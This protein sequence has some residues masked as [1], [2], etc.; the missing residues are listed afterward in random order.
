MLEKIQNL[1]INYLIFFLILFNPKINLIPLEGYHGIRLDD[2]L[3]AGTIIYFLINKKY[4]ILDDSI[5]KNFFLLL[6]YIFFVNF[7][8]IFYLIPLQSI[9]LIRSIEYLSLIII[10]NNL[11]VSKEDI[12]FLIK[13]FIFSNLFISILQTLDL[14]G[15]FSSLG[16][17]NVDHPNNLRA[18]GILGGSWE[19]AIASCLCYF[20]LYDQKNNFFYLLII[21]FLLYMAESRTSMVAFSLT[22]ILIHFDFIKKNLINLI[23]LSTISLL[24]IIV[25]DKYDILYNKINY[26][27][28]LFLDS[29]DILKKFF[30]YEKTLKLHEIGLYKSQILSLVYRTHEWEHML[31]LAKQNDL[32]FYFGAG[33]F[34]LYSESIFIRIFYS[35]GLIGFLIIFFISKNLPIYV[36]FFLIINGFTIDLFISI[37]IFTIFTLLLYYFKLKY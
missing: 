28:I 2:L 1:K 24:M 3:I 13:I 29:F 14:I 11:K 20:F 15:S 21:F 8:S 26:F 33:F 16:Y 32:M 34:N 23:L 5:F 9:M 17:L 18:Y 22:T 31:N 37:K 10:I 12:I 19:L 25:F 30:I 36:L 6:V 4:I 7:L 27:I 35:L